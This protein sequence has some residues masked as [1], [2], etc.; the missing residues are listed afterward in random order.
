MS[1]NYKYWLLFS[2][3]YLI[4]IPL[5][6]LS[7]YIEY[8]RKLR[9]IPKNIDLPKSRFGSDVNRVRNSKR[10]YLKK[11]YNNYYGTA[12]IPAINIDV[13]LT[14]FDSYRYK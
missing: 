6:M 1:E 5:S 8:R 7:I 3:M 14:I 9:K 11:E 13:F 4:W 12:L 10:K 2:L